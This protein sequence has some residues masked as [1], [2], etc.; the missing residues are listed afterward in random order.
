[1]DAQHQLSSSDLVHLRDAYLGTWTPFEPMHRLLSAW[2]VAR[3][4]GALHQAISYHS[5][6]SSIGPEAKQEM[7]GAIAYWLLQT[8]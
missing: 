3:R 6:F 7:D 5:I 4:L 2:A 8:L 1:D